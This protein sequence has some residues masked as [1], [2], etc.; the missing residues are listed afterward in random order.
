MLP[1]TAMDIVGT[2]GDATGSYN[3]ST[4]AAFVAAGAGQTVAKHG[5]RALSSKSGAADVLMALGVNIDVPPAK[6]SEAI[7][8]AGLGFMFAPSP[9]QLNEI[10]RPHD[11]W[12]SARGQSSTC[13]AP[14][15]TLL[16]S[17]DRSQAYSAATGL[18]RWPVCWP[19][20]AVKPFGSITVKVAS[21][22]LLQQAQAGSPSFATERQATLKLHLNRS[23]SSA[24]PSKN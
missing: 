20:S 17:S 18:N 6:I 24:Q 22:K 12:S 11:E 9:P 5:N 2:G 8:I 4:C 13:L 15:P 10:C 21:T 19:I 1:L 23:A 16:A 7:K 14:S 3:I